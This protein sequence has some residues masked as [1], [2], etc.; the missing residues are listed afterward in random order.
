VPVT[1][2]SGR[3]GRNSSAGFCFLLVPLP[4][5]VTGEIGLIAYTD[6]FLGVKVIVG[7]M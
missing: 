2:F 1:Q 5:G 4:S 3:H 7:S 6:D